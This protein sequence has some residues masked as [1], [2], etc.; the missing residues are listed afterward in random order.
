LLSSFFVSC[1]RCSFVF[2]LILELQTLAFVSVKWYVTIIGIHENSIIV[3]M[4]K[5]AQKK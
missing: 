3:T 1:F 4:T 2:G 5:R